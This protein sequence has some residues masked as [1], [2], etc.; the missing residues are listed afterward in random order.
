MPAFVKK[1]ILIFLSLTLIA[2]QV[3]GQ[4]NLV[5]NPSFEASTYCMQE[6]WGPFSGKGADDWDSF[7]GSADYMNECNS[8]RWTNFMGPQKASSGTGFAGFYA[9]IG[10]Y[11]NEREILGAKLTSPLV[12]GKTY[13]VSVKFSMAEGFPDSGCNNIGLLFLTRAYTSSI[14]RPIQCATCLK[15]LPDYAHVYSEQ[16][17]KD[18][19]NWTEV[20]GTFTADSGYTHIAIGNFFSDSRTTLE[21]VLPNNKGKNDAYYYVD[22]VSVI[23]DRSDNE[24]DESNNKL[25]MKLPNVFTP[26]NDGI[27][28]YFVP[29]KINAVKNMRMTIYNRWG[30]SVFVTNRVTIEWDGKTDNGEHATSGLYYW[31]IEYGD[32]NNVKETAKGW[33]ALIR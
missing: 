10:E 4:K 14:Y 25:E 24:E 32:D 13:Q 7:R 18:Y 30:K 20:A 5:P 17:I 15:Y 9:F 6:V 11:A 33:L 16:V 8:W 12:I 31:V 27:N 19:E 3:W 29:S 21:K 26:N 23:Q 2:L 28:D 1:N 22:D